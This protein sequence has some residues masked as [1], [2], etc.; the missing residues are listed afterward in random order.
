MYDIPFR[1]RSIREYAAVCDL[2]SRQIQR[3]IQTCTFFSSHLMSRH[4]TVIVFLHNADMHSILKNNHLFRVKKCKYF[5]AVLAIRPGFCCAQLQLS[6]VVNIAHQK[7][8]AIDRFLDCVFSSYCDA[9]LRALRL[10]TALSQSHN[11]FASSLLAAAKVFPSANRKRMV[12][13]EG[14]N[15]QNLVKHQNHKYVQL[16]TA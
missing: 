14:L 3:K 15:L 4:S 16:K 12:T 1:I 6:E 7:K 10:E 11:S 8:A 2:K 5:F 9:Q 13:A